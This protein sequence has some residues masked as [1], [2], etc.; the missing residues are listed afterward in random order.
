LDERG[1]RHLH[2]LNFDV[3]AH[4]LAHL[5][6]WAIVGA[7]PEASVTAEYLGF[8]ESAGDLSALIAVLHFDTVMDHVL[9][10]SAGNLYNLSELSRIGEISETS[11][12][13]TADNALRMRDVPDV[14]TPVDFLSQ[15]ARHLLAQ[16]LTGGVF[17]FFVDIYQRTLAERGL[18]T[19]SLD[20]ASGRVSGIALD[21]PVIG[22]M[23]AAAY[24]GRHEAFKRTL[25]DTRDY[26]GTLLGH[27]WRR[28]SPHYLTYRDVLHMLL[29]TDADL[30]GGAYRRTIV[31]SFEWRGIHLATPGR[32][33]MRGG[34]DRRA[35]S[36][37]PSAER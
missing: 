21:D 19:A 13:R 9:R 20:R 35:W 29:L 34:L 14:S 30:T 4:E 5:I 11:Q 10:R 12:I 16:P 6:I 3:V 15:P 37:F 25:A 22:A 23:F 2:C 17:D 27:A 26:V 8:Q 28:L 7:P 31:E 1:L 36:S 33:H 32:G 18:I 24:R